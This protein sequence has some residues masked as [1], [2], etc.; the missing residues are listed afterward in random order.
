MSALS[1]ELSRVYPADSRLNARGHIEVGGCDLVELAREYGTPAF[2]VA[3]EDLRRRA[4]EFVG[5]LRERHTDS[6]VVFA[7]KAF[8][9]TAVY[10]VFAEEGL[11]CDVASGGE[12]AMALRGGFPPDRIVVHGN[13][14][15]A[16]ELTAALDAGVGLIVL[17]SDDD[18]ARLRQLAATTGQ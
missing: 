7:S 12:L 16:A 2:V 1:T 6:R 9:C 10:R 3:E 5:A 14:K 11:D 4:R 18:V 17:D 15:S 13:A 8:P